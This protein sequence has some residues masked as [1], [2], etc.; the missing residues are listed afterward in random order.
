[1]R[2]T[3]PFPGVSEDDDFDTLADV[4]VS[5]VADTI[6]SSLTRR[7]FVGGS[8][9]A[10]S[11]DGVGRSFRSG[12]L[13]GLK[14]IS[15]GLVDVPATRRMTSMMKYGRPLMVWFLSL[16]VVLLKSRLDVQR[17]DGCNAWSHDTYKTYL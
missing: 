12:G 9:A 6:S 17:V 1:M 2:Y 16:L 13:N 14:G 5:F 4:V 8:C 10:F 15:E 7:R 11:V 3:E